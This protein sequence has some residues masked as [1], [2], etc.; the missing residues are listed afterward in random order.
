MDGQI[1]PEL[2]RRTVLPPLWVCGGGAVAALVSLTLAGRPLSGLALAVG[3][4]LGACNGV[5]AAR[6]FALPIP[7]VAS[8]LA[9][10]V[11]FS[12]LGVGLGLALGI[13]QVWL[14]IIGLAA[15]QLVLAAAALRQVVRR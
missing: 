3:L 4:L 15:A 11:L 14:V 12:V 8:S 5:L 2:A 10:I 7:F 13:S 1:V 9:R 6:L